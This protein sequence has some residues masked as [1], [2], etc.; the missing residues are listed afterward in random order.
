MSQRYGRVSD[1]A[2]AFRRYALLG[3][4]RRCLT[5]YEAY[6][7]IRGMC[8]SEAMTLDMLAV[9]DT[10]RLLRASEKEECIAAIRRVYFLGAG[11]RPRRNDV[12]FRI[13]RLAYELHCDERTIYRHLK[14]VK[15]LY[16][17]IRKNEV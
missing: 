16:E 10:L 11:R 14:Y 8:A 5:V 3:L 4:D 7:C 15:R 1:A 6:D 2:V 17:V 12:T 13:R 9:Y